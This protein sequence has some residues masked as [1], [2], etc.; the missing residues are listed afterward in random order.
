MKKQE[1]S[2]QP[3]SKMNLRDPNGFLPE[4]QSPSRN[5]QTA[6]AEGFCSS[7]MLPQVMSK[8][9]KIKTKPKPLTEAK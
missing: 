9:N 2:N 8:P 1:G 7:R 6:S 5:D 3:H 4:Y